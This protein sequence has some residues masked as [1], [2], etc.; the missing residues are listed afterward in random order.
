M[1]RNKIL[2]LS[3]L[4]IF[5]LTGCHASNNIYSEQICYSLLMPVGAPALPMYMEILMEEKVTTTTT[6]TTIPPEFS[7]ENYDFLIFDSTQAL[8]ILSKQENPLYEF[9]LMLTGGN[10]H[11]LG[12]DKEEGSL[13]IEGEN[14]YSFQQTGTASKMFANI[15]GDIIPEGN[16]FNAIGDLQT[17]LLKIDSEFKINNKKVDWAVVSEPQLTNLMNRWEENNIDTSK[18]I[19]INLQSAFKEANKETYE[20]DYIPQAALFVN[21]NFEKENPE[22]VLKVVERVN[23]AVNDVINNPNNVST[24][25]TNRIPDLNEQTAK[26][27]FNAKLIEEV[28]KEGRN[29]FGIVP[30]GIN[31]EMDET[32][33]NQFLSI[34]NKK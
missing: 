7:N 14:I 2:F 15:Y 18:I 17:E 16:Y 22:K 31:E 1:K 29:G 20:Y 24:T 21:R 34:V 13:P 10:F 19:D 5:S 12:F 30:V 28:Q 6:P 27:G 26:F 23:N 11:V 8:N 33:I 3:A 32:V 25:I 4:A 9:K